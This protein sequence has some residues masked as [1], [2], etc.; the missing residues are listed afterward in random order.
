MNILKALES[1]SP[2][3]EEQKS[4]NEADGAQEKPASENRDRPTAH[5]QSAAPP[6]NEMPQNVMIGVL[7]R[8]ERISNRVRSAKKQ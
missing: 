4:R 1:L 3:P 8:H 5:K 6:A 7:E 2:K